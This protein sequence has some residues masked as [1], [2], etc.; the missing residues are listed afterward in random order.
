MNK[1]IIGLVLKRKNIYKYSKPFILNIE[2]ENSFIAQ[3]IR[4]VDFDY[5]VNKNE[6]INIEIVKYPRLDSY[7]YGNI[8][9]S[10]HNFES[11]GKYNIL[12]DKLNSDYIFQD[13]IHGSFNVNL[14]VN[15]NLELMF[16]F[17]TYDNKY[18]LLTPM[19]TGNINYLRLNNIN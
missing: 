16:S 9:N 18:L 19:L 10:D 13:R 5:I 14:D 1:T 8:Q 12:C 15:F 7:Y 17:T 6:T 4:D 3:I 11:L 2:N